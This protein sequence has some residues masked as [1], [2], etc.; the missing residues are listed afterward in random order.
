MGPD[1]YQK[2]AHRAMGPRLRLTC[3]EPHSTKSA[4][5]PQSPRWPAAALLSGALP[6]RCKCGTAQG[7]QESSEHLFRLWCYKGQKGPG[8]IEESQP[9]VENPRVPGV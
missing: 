3:R 4:C 9:R 6:A 8:K 7:A 5:R 2:L 1:C